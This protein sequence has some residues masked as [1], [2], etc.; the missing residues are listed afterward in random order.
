MTELRANIPFL[1]EIDAARIVR[2]YGTLA[3]RLAGRRDALGRSRPR[4]RRRADARPK[5][6][7][8]KREEWAQTAE[9][10]LWRRTKLGLHMS[11][12]GQA[13]LAEYLGS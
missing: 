11:E 2:A 6:I 9:D 5:S 1:G 10:I 12:A 3:R 13:A 7:T 8:C 4:F